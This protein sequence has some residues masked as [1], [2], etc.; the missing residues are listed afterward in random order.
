MTILNYS[1]KIPQTLDPDRL[2]L[3]KDDILRWCDRA[4]DE[5][6]K[7]PKSNWQFIAGMYTFKTGIKMTPAHV[8]LDI[9]AKILRWFNELLYENA[10]EEMKT[11]NPEYYK[12][13][14]EIQENKVWF[15]LWKK[16]KKKALGEKNATK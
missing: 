5:W 12:L 14:K 15:E 13:M 1:G 11:G 2:Q 7:N 3:T 4:V 6:K 16:G 9:W 10:M 8:L